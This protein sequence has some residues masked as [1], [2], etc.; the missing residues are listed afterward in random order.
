M[1]KYACP[2][3]WRKYDLERERD[4]HYHY[5]DCSGEPEQAREPE[6]A[7]DADPF[8][9]IVERRIERIRETLAAKREEYSRDGD[10]LYNFRRAAEF[11]RTTM[12]QVCWNFAMK[13]LVSVQDIATDAKTPP[14]AVSDEKIGDAINYLIIL[15]A[16]LDAERR[17]EA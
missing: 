17:G 11:Q 4:H 16:I 2:R 8:N 14:F 3:C 15:E 12:K 10:K 6:Q 1:M 7:K 13:H 9:V 5:M